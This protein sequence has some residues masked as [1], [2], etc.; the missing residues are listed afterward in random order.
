MLLS[1][2]V[3]I[4]ILEELPD[5]HIAGLWAAVDDL[6]KLLPSDR[7]LLENETYHVQ[8]NIFALGSRAD[9][10]L[11]KMINTGF[12]AGKKDQLA[13]RGMGRQLK[14]VAIEIVGKAGQV[15]EDSLVT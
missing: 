14:E 5:N 4:I 1:Q 3:S 6:L 13:K 7:F 11:K 15:V 2:S 10:G 8:V 12:C 9:D